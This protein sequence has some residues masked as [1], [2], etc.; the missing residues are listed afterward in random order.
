MTSPPTDTRPVFFFDVDNCLYSRSKRVHDLMQDLMDQYFVS[1]L[2]LAP[3][4]ASRLHKTY[5]TQY[6]LALEG[7][8]RFHKIDPMEYNRLVDDALPLENVLSADPQLRALLEDLDRS[9]V[10][11]WLF[12]NAYVTHG[13]RVV[14][15]LGVQDMFEGIT[16]CDYKAQTLLCKPHRGMFEKAQAESGARSAQDCYFVDDSLPNCSKAHELGWT[17]VHLLEPSDPAPPTN[18]S[19]YQIRGLQELRQLFPQFFRSTATTNGA[20]EPGKP[21]G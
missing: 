4:D 12:T 7:L 18:P 15:L 20:V 11:P 1:H 10:K 14:R 8:V 19:H 16:F 2:A 5:Y 21:E 9:Q 3:E 13:M 17:A 6:G